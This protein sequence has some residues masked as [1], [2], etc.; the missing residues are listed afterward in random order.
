MTPDL[1]E[2]VTGKDDAYEFP[3]QAISSGQKGITS[4]KHINPIEMAREGLRVLIN[5]GNKLASTMSL[6]GDFEGSNSSAYFSDASFE[7][8]ELFPI[9]TASH[10]KIQSAVDPNCFAKAVATIVV[11]SVENWEEEEALPLLIEHEQAILEVWVPQNMIKSMLS[12]AN[13]HIKALSC[14]QKAKYDIGEEAVNRFSLPPEDK[15]TLELAEWVDSAFGRA[16]VED[17]VCRAA[18][19]TSPVQELDFSSLR[20]QLGPLPAILLCIDIAATSAKSSSISCKLLSQLKLRAYPVMVTIQLGCMQAQ[21]MLSEIYPGNSPKI[22]STYWDQIREVAV[23]SVI[24][25]VLKRLQEQLEQLR[26]YPYDAKTA[27]ANDKEIFSET[28]DEAYRQLRMDRNPKAVDLGL[29]PRGI[30]K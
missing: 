16:S 9:Q 5:E 23:I 3:V 14:M 21:I 7:I 8:S 15:A 22:G 13:K 1:V 24:K 26:I 2:G 4:A 25:R 10:A 6:I 17:A 20:A 27:L 18:D 29:S 11:I 28:G 12:K 19:G 30:P